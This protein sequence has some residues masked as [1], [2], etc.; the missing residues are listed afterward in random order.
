VGRHILILGIGSLESRCEGG[1][2]LGD[3]GLGGGSIEGLVVALREEMYGVLH[4]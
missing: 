3:R 4:L 2:W 1:C